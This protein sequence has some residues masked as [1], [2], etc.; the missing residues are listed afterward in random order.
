MDHSLPIPIYSVPLIQKVVFLESLHTVT[1]NVPTE[2]A[3]CVGLLS[4]PPIPPNSSDRFNSPHSSNREN[5]PL[6]D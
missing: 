1:L 2:L 5:P 6:L 4:A 3:D